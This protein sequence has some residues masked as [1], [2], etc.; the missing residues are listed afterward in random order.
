MRMNVDTWEETY[1]PINN[2]G[3]E[4]ASWNG[5]LFETYGNDEEAVVTVARQ[6][7]RRVW[8]L[9]DT[10]NTLSIVNGFHYVNRVGYFI[11]EEPWEAGATID[12]AVSDSDCFQ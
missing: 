5:Q 3:D 2:S 8:T 9:V 7:P 1:R 12:V 6:E 10:G 4:Y 11:T